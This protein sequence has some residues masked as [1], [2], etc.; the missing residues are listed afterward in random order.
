MR[1]EL[2]LKLLQEESEGKEHEKTK[3][4]DESNKKALDTNQ[5]LDDFLG[6]A[7]P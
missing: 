4:S 2:A 5:A 7:E 6:P 1:K 3:D